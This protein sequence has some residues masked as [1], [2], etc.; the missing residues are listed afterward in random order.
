[1]KMPQK[2]GSPEECPPTTLPSRFGWPAVI[3]AARTAIAATASFLIARVFRLPEA[4]WAAISTIVVLQST[5]GA[6]LQISQDRFLGTL[7]GA[8]TGG[9]LAQYFP[10][11]WWVFALGIFFLGIVCALSHLH[12]A[13]RFAG[14]TLAIVVLIPHTAAAPIV[15]LHRFIDVS[16]GIVVG[17]A[18]TIIWPAPATGE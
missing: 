4:Y 6:S 13:Y 1:M 14:I 15:A 5:L 10:P 8:V 17:L 3:N 11:V 12:N 18:V 16:I 2:P 7:I 9:L